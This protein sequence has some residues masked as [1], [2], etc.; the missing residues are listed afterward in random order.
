[1]QTLKTIFTKLAFYT[2]V[3]CVF[4]SIHG[5]ALAQDTNKSA[6]KED[7]ATNLWLMGYFIVGLGIVLGLLVLCR[8]AR[9]SDR[10]KPQE[11]KG[12]TTNE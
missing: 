11:Y 3:L 8:S 4:L 2:S 5:L 10:A 6:A 9:R 12:L 7:G 1:M